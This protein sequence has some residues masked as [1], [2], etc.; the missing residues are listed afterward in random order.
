M[1][2]SVH[3]RDNRPFWRGWTPRQCWFDFFFAFRTS[4]VLFLFLCWCL[5]GFDPTA[6][7]NAPITPVVGHICENSAHAV[8]YIIVNVGNYVYF[9]VYKNFVRQS[10]LYR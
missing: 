1:L 9:Y 8:L 2:V 3:A 7:F 5:G 6:L 4:R 10:E